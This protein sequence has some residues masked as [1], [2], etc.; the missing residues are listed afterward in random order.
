MNVLRLSK[1][2]QKF[3]GVYRETSTNWKD[4]VY[5]TTMIVVYVVGMLMLVIGSFLF[6]LI[7]FMDMEKSTNAMIIMMAG[8]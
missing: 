4:I 6:I 1:T 8:R 7:N 5:M 3:I 2:L